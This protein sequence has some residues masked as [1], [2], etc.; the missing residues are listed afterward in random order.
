MTNTE[1]VRDDRDEMLFRRYSGHNPAFYQR[2]TRERRERARQ[3][4]MARLAEERAREA[5][6]RQTIDYKLD[7]NQFVGVETMIDVLAKEPMP[8]AHYTVPQMAEFVC[9]RWKITINQLVEPSLQPRLKLARHHLCRAIILN[10][11][12]WSSS[13]VGEMMDRD[14]NYVNYHKRRLMCLKR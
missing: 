5:A 2:V 13:R 4:E 9:R 14:A 10:R 7:K 11:P 6:R 1:A 12:D 3:A 8:P